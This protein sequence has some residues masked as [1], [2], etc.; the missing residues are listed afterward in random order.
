MEGSIV[1]D[2]VLASC[3]AYAHHDLVHV[4]MTPIRWFPKILEWIFGNENGIPNY[5][6]MV[7]ELGM[8]VIPLE[9]VSKSQ[10]SEMSSG[11]NLHL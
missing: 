4:A 5:A 3:Y 6:G 1:V 9:P 8:W 11:A 7:D 2:D 10:P